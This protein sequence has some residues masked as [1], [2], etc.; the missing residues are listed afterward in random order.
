MQNVSSFIHKEN[1]YQ[2]LTIE[3]ELFEKA[4]KEAENDKNCMSINS[5]NI[6]RYLGLTLDQRFEIAKILTENPLNFQISQYIKEFNLTDRSMRFELAKIVANK[7][8]YISFGIENYDLNDDELFE[9]AKIAAG[10]KIGAQNLIHSIEK[11]RIRDEKNRYEI[12]TIAARSD[13]VFTLSRFPSLKISGEYIF[14]IAKILIEWAPHLIHFSNLTNNFSLTHLQYFELAK[15]AA[16]DPKSDVYKSLKYFYFF[17]DKQ[18]FEIAK[19]F[20][21]TVKIAQTIAEFNIKDPTL[22]FKIAKIVLK[23][24]EIISPYIL[25]FKIA[26]SK[27]RYKI[28]KKVA[29]YED[30]TPRI[31]LFQ[32]KN[33][34]Q[35]YK[36]AKMVISS[37]NFISNF[38]F[39][40]IEDPNQRYE[41]AKM[42]ALKKDFAPEFKQF[43]IEDP[44][45]RYELAKMNALDGERISGIA[46]FIDNFEITNQNHLFEIAMI[47][48]NKGQNIISYIEKFNIESIEKRFELAKLAIKSNRDIYN[49]EGFQLN[50]EQKVELFLKLCRDEL[51]SE[52]VQES[53]K[54]LIISFEFE[55][56]SEELLAPWRGLQLILHPLSIRSSD[57]NTPLA[58]LLEAEPEKLSIVAHTNLRKWMGYYL[59]NFELFKKGNEES[60]KKYYDEMDSDSLLLSIAK[61]RNPAKRYQLTDL[62]FKN[63]STD[64]AGFHNVHNGLKHSFGNKSSPIFK[65]LITQLIHS[66][67][68]EEGSFNKE[69]ICL[70]WKRVFSTLSSSVY[71]DAKAQMTVID[72]LYTLAN[73]ISLT[74]REKCRLIQVIFGLGDSIKEKKV[75]SK[76]INLNLRLM[77]AIIQSGY[78]EVLKQ[79]ILLR[80]RTQSIT[81]DSLQECLKNIF[82]SFIGE[83][84]IKGFAEKFENTFLKSRQPTAFITYASK[85]QSLLRDDDKADEMSLRSSLQKFYSDVMN[86]TFQK[87][88]YEI[89]QHLS[90]VFSWKE[91]FKEIWKTGKRK[92][93]QDVSEV[94]EKE[95]S[96]NKFNPREYLFQRICLDKHIDFAEYTTLNFLS[97]PREP[98]SN[99]ID[100]SL[101]ELSE[102]KEKLKNSK[103]EDATKHFHQLL[104]QEKIISLCDPRKNI[105]E[106]EL[107]FKE[108]KDCVEK[109]FNS[110]D[111]QFIQDLNG[112][113]ILMKSEKKQQ[114]NL[115]WFVEETDVWDD[116]LL[117]GT[118]VLGS[119]QN[120]HGQES[121][122]K[123]LLNYLLD[124]KN[125]IVVLKNTE[126]QI[127]ARVI[128]RLLWD[129]EKK[130]PI[131]FQERLY[132]SPEVLA[133]SLDAINKMCIEKARDLGITL[134]TSDNNEIAGDEPYPNSIESL[135][136]CAPFEYVDADGLGTTN[137]TFT[138]R[139]NSMAI[140]FDPIRKE[141]MAKN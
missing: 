11:Y 137:G 99:H 15:I 58:P 110:K 115:N 7:Y 54:D 13:P 73:T 79:F 47:V 22:L 128:L 116:L 81:K 24:R 123:C 12:A 53:I 21:Q 9:I 5:I 106:R 122:N 74:P 70:D 50:L 91:G 30:I 111:H 101:Q 87:N 126:G 138:I 63:M 26:S 83:V 60:F 131:L 67:V 43:K 41:L 114:S 77:E 36:I 71:K 84:E 141:E 25:H 118:E 8:S 80:P 34:K 107:L 38:S 98:I 121:L 93:I 1:N 69:Q 130:C 39:F 76:I 35:R 61:L 86:G 90:T 113:K 56:M 17:D 2:Q 103:E 89:G 100:S 109:I 27:M 51:N 31:D 96:E 28:A 94:D 52:D 32:I 108:A 85:L 66:Q 95:R 119:C 42:V 88:R 6:Q 125:R 23:K 104:L 64:Q 92:L 19:I 10:T 55:K 18:R 3:N 124:G 132:T 44:N 40:Q 48:L 65:F 127:R 112:L 75:K 37:D 140:I 62:H 59:L 134:V 78:G 16:L 57:K 46:R 29:V 102:M 120:I 105:Q 129:E 4:K 72:S 139:P 82:L 136:G 14:D 49:L 20:S 117:C 68:A 33:P 135:N 97:N 133:S 45:Q